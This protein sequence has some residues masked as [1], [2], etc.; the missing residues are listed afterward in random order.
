MSEGEYKCKTG[1]TYHA[2]A[3][4][5]DQA[6][7]FQHL[8]SVEIVTASLLHLVFQNLPY[9][10]D[11]PDPY[12]NRFLMTSEA[13]IYSFC[14]II[15]SPSIIL[16]YNNWWKLFWY[17]HQTSSHSLKGSMVS[18]NLRSYSLVIVWSVNIYSPFYL[19][20]CL[21]FRPVLCF[22]HSD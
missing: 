9:L 14:Y 16:E 3:L 10:T 4:G 22:F 5:H 12:S 19:S 11:A 8:F 17:T 1:W 20:T 21:W 13:L 18:F 15:W 6:W 2:D 7:S